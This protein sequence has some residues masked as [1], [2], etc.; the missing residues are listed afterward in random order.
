[1]TGLEK[2]QQFEDFDKGVEEKQLEINE[3]EKSFEEY[4]IK[5]T[6]EFNKSQESIKN[7]IKEIDRQKHD[8]AK[9]NPII[10]NLADLLNELAKITHQKP[11]VNLIVNM[12]FE[13]F[14]NYSES[15]IEATFEQFDKLSCKLAIKLNNNRTFFDPY[16]DF[17]FSN[18]VYIHLIK[19]DENH[20][21]NCLL[22]LFKLN[23]LLGK[24]I[25]I[26]YDLDKILVELSLYDIVM[27]EEV[28]KA[29]INCL[30]PQEVKGKTKL[31]EKY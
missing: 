2:I 9:D 29:V 24:S 7:E 10:I 26:N 16:L 11:E 25:Y 30:K 19:R 4:L 27:Y 28:K 21:N 15:T 20:K 17:H 31:L 18:Q 6:N 23:N 13:D 14:K 12:P 1:M 3:R 8:Y 5:L 22:K